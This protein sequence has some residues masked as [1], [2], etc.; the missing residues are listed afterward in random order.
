MPSFGPESS[1]R[2]V[3]CMRYQMARCLRVACGRQLRSHKC[4]DCS[5]A[6][7]TGFFMR[8]CK[9]CFGTGL[10]WRCPDLAVHLRP[11]R[12]PAS[13]GRLAAAAQT[14][15]APR[16]R[17]G[18][19][20]KLSLADLQKQRLMAQAAWANNAWMPGTPAWRM[21]SNA[22][23]SP[24]WTQNRNAAGSPAWMNNQPHNRPGR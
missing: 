3:C 12:T 24:A 6:G 19:A 10:V 4:G 20:A 13:K 17:P 16:L 5:G 23:G 11:S 14:T 1:R 18:P 15:A 8:Q 21:N 7:S 9:S 22:P 2:L